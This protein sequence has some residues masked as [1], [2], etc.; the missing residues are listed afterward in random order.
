MTLWRRKS[1]RASST[2]PSAAHLNLPPNHPSTPNNDI[3][4]TTAPQSAPEPEQRP[5]SRESSSS[6]SFPL[7]PKLRILAATWG[8]AIITP[9]LRDMI[10]PA[11]QSLTL[12]ISTLYAILQPDPAPNRRKILTLAYQFG[13]EKEEQIH[14]LN[15]P[16][17][18]PT[19][20]HD[21]PP[22]DLVITISPD[23]L[24]H[25]NAVTGGIWSDDSGKIEILGVFYGPK[26]IQNQSVMEQLGGY[27]SGRIWQIRGIGNAFFGEDPWL[28]TQ[29]SWTVYF[30]F[31]GSNKGVQ[32]VTGW[33]GAVL[34]RPWGR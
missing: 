2:P 16:E 8:G 25:L 12:N 31:L 13:Q 28:F 15:L 21:R 5:S 6:S 3:S 33:E 29:K 14:I 9:S 34:E 26:R 18:D 22:E 27:F 1:R 4:S 23:T 11:T 17:P 32:V 30:R 24:P 19:S 20:Y 10:E 7:S